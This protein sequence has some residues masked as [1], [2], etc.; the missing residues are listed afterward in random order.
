MPTAMSA[1]SVSID[2]ATSFFAS[3]RPVALATSRSSVLLAIPAS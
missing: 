3:D 1:M 2:I